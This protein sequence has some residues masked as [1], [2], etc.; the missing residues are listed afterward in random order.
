MLSD[1]YSSETGNA[2]CSW[3]IADIAAGHS[4]FCILTAF[5]TTASFPDLVGIQILLASQDP[6]TSLITSELN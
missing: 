6:W 1:C 3:P 5:E 4:G 2:F